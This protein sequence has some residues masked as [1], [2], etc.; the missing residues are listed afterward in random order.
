M[1]ADAGIASCLFSVALG[2]ARLHSALG[3]MQPQ[4]MKLALQAVGIG[5]VLTACS[6]FRGWIAIDS[7]RRGFPLWFVEVFPG[8]SY[9]NSAGEGKDI[10]HFRGYEPLLVNLLV[11]SAVAYVCLIVFRRMRRA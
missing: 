9:S 4:A 10:W 11:W 6:L 7:M 3:D 1:A 5:A 2:P 8:S